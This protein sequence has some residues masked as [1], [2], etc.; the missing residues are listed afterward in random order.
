MIKYNSKN[1]NLINKFI[2]KNELTYIINE[3][4]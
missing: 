4:L 3:L 2:I 1:D